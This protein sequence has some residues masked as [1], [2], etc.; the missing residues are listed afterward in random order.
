MTDTASPAM[1]ARRQQKLAEETSPLDT[2][3]QEKALAEHAAFQKGYFRHPELDPSTPDTLYH[4]SKRTAFL[5][6]VL[7][8]LVP[9]GVPYRRDKAF[10]LALV[11]GDEKNGIVPKMNSIYGSHFW[12]GREEKRG[13]FYPTLVGG[14]NGTV[15]PGCCFDPLYGNI[16]RYASSLDGL[17]HAIHEVRL[18]N[19]RF[20]EMV[21]KYHEKISS[22]L[23]KPSLIR[24]IREKNPQNPIFCMGLPESIPQVSRDQVLDTPSGIR[25]Y[26]FWVRNVRD[27]LGVEYLL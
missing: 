3:S 13:I 24:D 5:T 23:S 16:V 14:S 2:R 8:E 15:I 4:H 12:V 26:D 10:A 20:Q 11:H 6:D 1:L 9:K 19:E 22:D 17:C 27:N 7:S 21:T 18:G 25:C